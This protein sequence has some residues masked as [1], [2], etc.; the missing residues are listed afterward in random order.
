MGFRLRPVV[1]GH[2]PVAEA[3]EEGVGAH[4]VERGGC[5]GGCGGR[6]LGEERAV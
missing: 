5:Y 1:C 3:E 2:G 6:G 4:E